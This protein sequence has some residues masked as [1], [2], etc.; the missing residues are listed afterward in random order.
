ML[1][2]S[3]KLLIITVGLAT[4]NTY[5]INQSL[6]TGEKFEIYSALARGPFASAAIF[7]HHK[8]LHAAPL[9]KGLAKAISITN[10]TLN[11][12]NKGNNAARLQQTLRITHDLGSIAYLVNNIRTGQNSPVIS[13][14]AHIVSMLQYVLAYI[15]TGAALYACDMNKSIS[16]QAQHRAQALLS[17]AHYAND[18]LMEY[19]DPILLYSRAMYC[20]AALIILARD[21]HNTTQTN[22]KKDK[23]PEAPVQKKSDVENN[24]ETPV[25]SESKSNGRSEEELVE[26]DFPT[27]ASSTLNNKFHGYNADD[28]DKRDSDTDFIFSFDEEADS[29]SELSSSSTVSDIPVEEATPPVIE[30]TDTM[31]IDDEENI[32]EIEDVEEIYTQ[33]ITNLLY[34]VL[35]SMHQ[36]QEHY[37]SQPCKNACGYVHQGLNATQLKMINLNSYLMDFM[38]P[39]KKANINPATQ[40]I[41]NDLKTL[42]HACNGML[43]NINQSIAAKSAA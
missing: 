10:D 28:I 20:V 18:A 14:Y 15:E 24:Q 2:F 17:L 40:A 4:T 41:L 8:N 39:E 12:H 25:N 19:D 43:S 26:E 30:H 34:T 7:A 9:F 3:W 37:I 36:I 42:E 1:N 16:P 22:Q 33:P 32:F 21:E 6:T 11:I 13:E 29:D 35:N 23:Q 5:A 31:I 27:S 38:F